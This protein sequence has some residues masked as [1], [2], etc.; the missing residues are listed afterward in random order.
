MTGVDEV[1]DT[2][3]TVPGSDAPSGDERPARAPTIDEGRRWYVSELMLTLELGGLAAFA[4]SRPILDTFGRSPD[5]FVARGA[6]AA[7][8]VLFGLIVG[9]GPYLV[10]GLLALLGRPFGPTVRRRVHIV[11]VGLVGGCAVWQIVQGVTGYPP[12]SEKAIVA[13]VAGGLAIGFLRASI[14]STASFLRFLGAASIVFL[15]QFLVMS[16]TASLVSGEGTA[17]D[18]DVAQQVVA[19]LGDD[20]PDVVVVVFDA[21]P[22]ASLLD[23]E[24]AIDAELFPN[25]ARLADTSSWYRNNTT[26]A[27]LTAQAVPAILTGRFRPL[28][29][30]FGQPAPEDDENLFT[31]LGGSYE[32]HANEEV[33][34][35]CPA[36][37]C[38][39]AESDGIGVL[40]ADALKTWTGAEGGDDG[41]SH[42]PGALG[43]DRFDDAAAWAARQSPAS[44]DPQLYFHHIVLPHAPWYL[45]AEGDTYRSVGSLPTGMGLWWGTNEGAI[46]VGVQRHILQIQAADALLGQLLDRL[47]AD[48]RF[49][50]SMI[51]VTADHGSSFLP[52]QFA[53]RL[54]EENMEQILWTP[55]LI[56]A[57]G[58]TEPVVDDANVMSIDVVPTIA[59]ALGVDL[60]W[61]VDGLPIEGSGVPRDDDTKYTQYHKANELNPP[62][63]EPI[64]EIDDTRARFE[65]VLAFDRVEATGADAV[66]RRTPHGDLFGRDVADL[67]VGATEATIAVDRLDDIEDSGRDDPLAEIVGDASLPMGTT[68]AYAVNGTIGAVVEVAAPLDGRDALTIGLVPPRLFRD[69]G[70]ELTAYVVD[71]PVGSETLREV[72]VVDA[73]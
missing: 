17:I 49:D 25:F 34:R 53:R 10:L 11:L 2:G 23:G 20:P 73:G 31:L 55:L 63:D 32:T 4:F 67:A 27:A 51:V 72:R 6:N 52:D 21:L 44:T 65:N 64:L 59:E 28:G 1:S 38:P 39:D 48:D 56:K 16:P 19:D 70:N 35:L 33:T 61:E 12:E 47:E 29:T 14:G 15:V 60:P 9:V 26:V 46:A 45:T 43:D 24:G 36:D 8:I 66:Y 69:G 41:G 30:D 57:P 37:T 54:T 40:L 58:Q 71:G 13:G 68:V 42:L 22:T 3:G 62:D 18:E 50:D 5:T 7:T